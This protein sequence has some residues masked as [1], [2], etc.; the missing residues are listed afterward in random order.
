VGWERV[1]NTFPLP[2]HV[3]LWNEWEAVSKWLFFGCVP[4]PFFVS[5]TA[6]RKLP[7]TCLCTNLLESWDMQHT[8]LQQLWKVFSWSVAGTSYE[9]RKLKVLARK[10]RPQVKSY[11]TTV[12][13][14]CC[15]ADAQFRKTAKSRSIGQKS[16]PAYLDASCHTKN[17]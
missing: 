12:K 17:Q 10:K 2:F 5:T 9:W 6:L 1:G 3:L 13:V 15:T 7:A 4:T 14:R 16:F 11:L 8:N